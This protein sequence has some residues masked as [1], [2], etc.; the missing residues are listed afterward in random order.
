MEYKLE[1]YYTSLIQILLKL[2]QNN[3][4]VALEILSKYLFQFSTISAREACEVLMYINCC[5]FQVNISN[6]MPVQAAFEIYFTEN[7]H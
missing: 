6:R 4:Y 7:S 5:I 2:V 3:L 1:Y